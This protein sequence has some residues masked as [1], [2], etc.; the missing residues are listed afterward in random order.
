MRLNTVIAILILLPLLIGEVSAQEGDGVTAK[1]IFAE[2]GIGGLSAGGGFIA[3]VAIGNQLYK[4]T[5]QH[6]GGGLL[7]GMIGWSIGGALGVYL[8]GEYIGDDSKNDA[9]TLGAT[10]GA[11]L[12]LPAI[13]LFFKI[14]PLTTWGT[15]FSPL[16]SLVTYNLVKRPAPVEEGKSGKEKLF[17]ISILSISL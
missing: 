9:L 14:K 6:A 3:G 15:L 5:P 12:T 2:A 4:M 10:L 17:Y 7:G 11:G 16:V 13:G 8:A 1:L